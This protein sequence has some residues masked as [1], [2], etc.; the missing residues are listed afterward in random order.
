MDADHDPI[1]RFKAVAEAFCGSIESAG[2]RSRD[3]F[4]REVAAALSSLYRAAL[5]VPDVW[6]DDWQFV[7]EHGPS[8]PAQ[9]RLDAALRQML[10]DADMYT[11]VVAYGEHEGEEVGGHSL[12]DD[13]L[14]IYVEVFVGLELLRSGSTPGEAAWMWRFG[15]WGHW[16]EHAVQA[17]SFTPESLRTSAGRP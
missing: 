3:D 12:S 13:L 16:G 5:D 15:F 1:L 14:D 17:A 7:G 10:S 6:D 9:R 2:T 11:T 4:L 8:K